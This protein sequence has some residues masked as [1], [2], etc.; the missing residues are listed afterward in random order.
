MVRVVFLLPDGIVGRWS[1][2]GDVLLSHGQLDIVRLVLGLL[3]DDDPFS[4]EDDIVIAVFGVV[5]VEQDRR[6]DDAGNDDD[7][8]QYNWQR[9]CFED[10]RWDLQVELL[11]D[12]DPQHEGAG[13][14]EDS[15]TKGGDSG[16]DVVKHDRFLLLLA[17]V[18]IGKRTLQLTIYS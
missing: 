2:C 9:F 7:R 16:N 13:Q 11:G 4:S 15:G 6:H 10:R 12:P 1:P 14:C 17:V 3:G 18:V 5:K 8:N